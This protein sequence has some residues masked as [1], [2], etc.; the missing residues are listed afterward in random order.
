MRVVASVGDP[1]SPSGGACRRSRWL[2]SGCVR[3]SLLGVALAIGGCA[4]RPA[5]SLDPPLSIDVA[6]TTAPSAQIASVAVPER[7]A[8]VV[9]TDLLSRLRT[10]LP[11]VLVRTQIVAG[12]LE[13]SVPGRFSHRED[14]P[15]DVWLVEFETTPNAVAVVLVDAHTGAGIVALASRRQQ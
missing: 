10:G 9:A 6:V 7:V 3:I 4:S 8:E 2:C 1:A 11:F 12:L 15:T 13:V 5:Q 14:R